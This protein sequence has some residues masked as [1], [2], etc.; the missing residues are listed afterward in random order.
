MDTSLV[1]VDVQPS[2]VRVT[3]KGKILQLRLHSEVKPDSSSAK[4]SQATGHLLVTM[5]KAKD[6]IIGE[7][8]LRRRRG[9]GRRERGNDGWA[10]SLDRKARNLRVGRLRERF[11]DDDVR[12][13]VIF[14]NGPRGRKS[15]RVGKKSRGGH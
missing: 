4:R 10:R 5:P 9:K 12:E 6:E 13:D 11:N 2:Y 3:L 7:K 1:D 8:Y 15:L 14:V